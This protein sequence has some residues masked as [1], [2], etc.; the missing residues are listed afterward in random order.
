MVGDR[1]PDVGDGGP[2]ITEFVAGVLA[3]RRS[4]SNSMGNEGKRDMTEGEGSGRG[5]LMVELVGWFPGSVEGTDGNSNNTEAPFF[6]EI[7]S[8]SSIEGNALENSVMF[9]L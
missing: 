1:A 7:P 9:M 3:G 4:G 6:L 8:N 2:L 5:P